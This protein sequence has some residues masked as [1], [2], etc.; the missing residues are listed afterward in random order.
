MLYLPFV[1][2]LFENC[3]SPSKTFSN[4]HSAVFELHDLV[5]DIYIAL[6]AFVI[7]FLII[8][9]DRVFSEEAPSI[10]REFKLLAYVLQN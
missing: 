10:F 1:D 7:D 2:G 5:I 3:R 6:F 9:R 4:V 8:Q